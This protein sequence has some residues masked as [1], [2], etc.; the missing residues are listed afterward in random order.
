MI[1]KVSDFIISLLPSNSVVFIIYLIV[2]SFFSIFLIFI[3]SKNKKNKQFQNNKK[4]LTI[5]DLLNIAKNQKSTLKDL[6][7][8]LE[9]F[10]NNFKV[11]N[12]EK[13]SFE[14]F[15]K[16]LNHKNRSKILFDI[17]HGKLLPSNLEY[18]DRLDKIEKE[19]LNK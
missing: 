9:Y 7:F 12:N 8:I 5:D 19:A 1:E 14:L 10:L 16:V 15:K 6:I 13:K 3:L 4:E 18:K 17:Y 2:F 11:K